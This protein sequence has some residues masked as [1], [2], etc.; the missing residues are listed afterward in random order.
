MKKWYKKCPYCCNEVKKD[1]IKCQYCKEFL[2]SD[3]QRECPFCMNKIDKNASIC[4]FCDEK[5]DRSINS[6]TKA[7]DWNVTRGNRILSFVLDVIITYTFIWGIV[8]IFL[9]L[10][11][12]RTTLGN[13]IV[14]INSLNN[15][16]SKISRKQWILRFFIF[17]PMFLFVS[18]IILAFVLVAVW[19]F[20]WIFMSNIDA[21]E[22]GYNI[23][24]AYGSMIRIPCFVLFIMNVVEVFFSCPTY[25][26]R[27]IWMKR[28]RQKEQ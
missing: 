23:W 14:W 17:N 7:N 13:L 9:V 28:V 24:Y 8:N 3:E 15:D 11:K 1:A 20:I 4:P 16:W 19:F 21:G 10:G 27:L 6:A 25:I 2:G 18:L 12:K 22:I 5:L 26:D